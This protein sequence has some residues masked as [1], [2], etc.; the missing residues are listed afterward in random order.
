VSGVV[1]LA[2]AAH[3]WP[4]GVSQRTRFF[5]TPFIGRL[6]AEFAVVP[7]G[8]ALAGPA[9]RAV[10]APDPVP[11]NYADRIGAP[12]AIRPRTFV[13]NAQD[14]VDLNDH[15][16]RQSARYGEIR[17]PVEILTGDTDPI[18][19][20]AIHA[21][22]LARDIAGA[23]LTELPGAGHMP[24]WSRTAEVVA[25]IDRVAGEASAVSRAAE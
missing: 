18:V 2:P 17:A 3:P 12:L 15:V 23:R 9:I 6:A 22:G 7:L 4:G 13:A 16:K 1:F 11:K 10:F 14:V 24:H 5:A 20:P 21:Y 8:L 19:F 25:A